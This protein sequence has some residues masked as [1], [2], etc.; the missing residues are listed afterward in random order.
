MKFI[1]WN[2]N[3]IRACL[4]KGFLDYFN[5]MNADFFAIQETK[6]QDGQVELPLEG[7]Y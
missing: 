5:E 7:Y 4:K 6:C 3:G 2:V 1:S